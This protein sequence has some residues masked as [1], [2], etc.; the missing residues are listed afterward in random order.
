ML[1]IDCCGMVVGGPNTS[2]VGESVSPRVQSVLYI[3]PCTRVNGRR[4]VTVSIQLNGTSSGS[5]LH[6]ICCSICT[7]LIPVWLKNSNFIL[8]IC[9][10]L[11]VDMMYRWACCIFL[12]EFSEIVG[13]RIMSGGWALQAPHP[14]QGG[15][16]KVWV[17]NLLI[18]DYTSHLPLCTGWYYHNTIPPSGFKGKIIVVISSL[19]SALAW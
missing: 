7:L 16:S 2:V 10:W 3:R 15:E 11:F 1:I 18:T 12:S 8:H 6:T 19:L 4:H 9:R 17:L 13:W 14:W 5:V